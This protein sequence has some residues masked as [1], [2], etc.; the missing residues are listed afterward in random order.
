MSDNGITLDDAN[1]ARASSEQQ[2]L[3]PP[4]VNRI[5]SADIVDALEAGMRDFKR[6]PL[7]GLFFGLVFAVG[8]NI[9]V[10]T[11]I[12]T[13]HG[14]L[15]YPL[16]VGF[17]MIGPFIAVG[18]YEV[19]RRL[20]KGEPIKWGS[21][22]GV[23][24]AQHRGELAWMAFVVM[25][26]LLMWMFEIRLLV[27]LF[28]GFQG[29][30]T[31]G[32]FVQTVVST[33]QGLIFLAVGHIVG[34][35][36]SLILFSITVVSFPMLLEKDYDFV[37]AMITSVKVVLASPTVMILWGLAITL[38]LLISMAPFFLGLVFSLPVLGHTTWHL[39][40]RAVSYPE[41]EQAQSADSASK[42]D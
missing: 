26:I 27:A 18:L 39:Y 32:D 34:A 6:A 11:S 22:L 19:S 9:V 20:E 3:A 41:A 40:R 23:I 42:S 30:A 33:Q 14:Y 5:T 10:G 13:G 4:K 12:L 38:E 29:F 36:F 35:I 37:T 16:A 21:V 28:L 2:R 31:L 7:I 8:G 17:W 1:G 25:F 24:W 15:S